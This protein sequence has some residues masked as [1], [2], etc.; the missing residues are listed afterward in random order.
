MDFYKTYD[1]LLHS[2]SAFVRQTR[3]EGCVFYCADDPVLTSIVVKG[4][5]RAVSYGLSKESDVTADRIRVE[6]CRSSFVCQ[7]R[8]REVGAF[9]LGLMGRHNVVNALA[10]I[11]LGIELG[12]D[13]KQI[14]SALASFKG[15]ERRFQVKYE[16]PH[17]QIVDDY[18]HHPTEIAA[19]IA[20]AKACLRDRV[21]VVFQPHRYS[22]TQALMDRFAQSF[23]ECDSL[24]LT[25]IYGA[26]EDPVDGVTAHAL[27]AKIR[28]Q[29]PNLAV[30]YVPKD[31]IVTRL[32][33]LVRPNDLVLFLGAGDITKVSDEFARLYQK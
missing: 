27:I 32:Q 28:S 33:T 2:F 30:D 9:S 7:T 8:G 15:V 14:Q 10:V 13:G 4:G 20:G 23:I 25:D 1:N 17:I 31:M 29:Q 22:R 3:K 6:A 19:T 12:I 26:G 18:G 24:L 11:A 5:V 16:D 21:V